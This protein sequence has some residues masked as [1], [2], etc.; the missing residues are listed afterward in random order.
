MAGPDARVGYKTTFEYVLEEVTRDK[1][2]L[3]KKRVKAGWNSQ[4]RI[5]IEK[6]EIAKRRHVRGN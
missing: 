1:E 3:K 2:M 5:P 6:L 4:R